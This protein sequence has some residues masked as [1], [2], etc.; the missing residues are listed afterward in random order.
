[1]QSYVEVNEIFA[2]KTVASVRSLVSETLA[3][4]LVWIHDYH[5]ML[6]A[7]LLRKVFPVKVRTLTTHQS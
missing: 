6:V 5:L 4:P 3:R 1:M 7:K 2:E